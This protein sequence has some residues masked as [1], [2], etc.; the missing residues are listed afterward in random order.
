M[1]QELTDLSLEGK[2]EGLDSG[3]RPLSPLYQRRKQRAGMLRELPKANSED[4]A[5]HLS[6]ELLGQVLY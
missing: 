3:Y 2:Q 1:R 6:P 5:S 4:A